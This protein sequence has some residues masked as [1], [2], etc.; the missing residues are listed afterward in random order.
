[1][2]GIEALLR[3]EWNRDVCE[4]Y[5]NQC[6]WTIAGGLYSIG[7][8]SFDMPQYVELIHPETKKAQPSAQQIKDDIVK[9][10]LEG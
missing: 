7:G 6:L 5:A 9:R 3:D 1:M 4:A 8:Q 10:L 2:S